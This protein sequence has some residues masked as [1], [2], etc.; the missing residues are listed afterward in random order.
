MQAHTLQQ[1]SNLETPLVY[2]PLLKAL[3]PRLSQDVV[4]VLNAGNL[5]PAEGDEGRPLW[6]VVGKD[7]EPA[8]SRLAGMVLFTMGSNPLNAL[9]QLID[10]VLGLGLA[11]IR[12]GEGGDVDHRVTFLR[13]DQR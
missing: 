13:L 9:V 6:A 12:N 3:V 11:S 5:V 7:D 10:D 8:E 4:D 1:K 2:R